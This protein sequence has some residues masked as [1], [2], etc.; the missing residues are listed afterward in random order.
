MSMPI[1]TD[2]S[3]INDLTTVALKFFVVLLFAGV[4]YLACRAH[5]QIAQ[6]PEAAAA[7]ERP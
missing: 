7:A 1:R 6:T 4:V 2:D 5:H 3:I